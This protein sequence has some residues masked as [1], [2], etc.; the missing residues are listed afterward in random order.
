MK[1]RTFTDEQINI[2]NYINSLSKE[3]L[4][5]HFSKGNTKLPFFN[6]GMPAVFCCP[7]ACKHNADCTEFCYALQSENQYPDTFKANYENYIFFKKYP[8]LFEKQLV[9]AIIEYAKTCKKKGIQ[10]IVRLCESGDIFNAKYCDMLLTII[11]TMQNVYFYGYTKNYFSL[12]LVNKFPFHKMNNCNLMLSKIEGIEIP[13]KYN[14]L[15]KIAYT[16]KLAGCPELI[17]N[18]VVHCIGNCEKCHACIYGSNNVFFVIHG[19]G[20]YDFIPEKIATP[21]QRNGLT[22]PVLEKYVNTNNPN[23]YKTSAKT[24]QGIRN[25]YCKKIIN[26]NT[27][28]DRTIN[29]LTVYQLYRSGK[30][31]IYK[32]GF[33]LNV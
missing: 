10:P 27:Y 11:A 1:K 15:Y 5:I 18:K 19:S 22:I 2:M 21:E 24:F 14:G 16:T 32:N 9:N 28:E 8:D 12:D 13:K 25:I 23:F 31:E 30:I 29:L 6:F 4:K 7:D 26:K 3:E 33:L 17:K 20:N